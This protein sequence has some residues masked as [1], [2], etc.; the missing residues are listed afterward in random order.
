MQDGFDYAKLWLNSDSWE[1]AKWFQSVIQFQRVCVNCMTLALVPDLPGVVSSMVSCCCS[2]SLSKFNI[3][4]TDCIPHTLV[5]RSVFFAFNHLK[6]VSESLQTFVTNKAFLNR[7][8][9]L[10]MIT[11]L[12]YFERWNFEEISNFLVTQSSQTAMSKVIKSFFFLLLMEALDFSK[13]SSPH[14]DS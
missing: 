12:D 7:S 2:P 10:N 9:S 6:P 1:Q 5:A 3:V 8:C 11:I 14:L 4:F 13:S